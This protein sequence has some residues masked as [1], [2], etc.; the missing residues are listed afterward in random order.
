[1]GHKIKP[2]WAHLLSVAGTL[3]R[4]PASRHG[5]SVPSPQVLT[6]VCPEW[7]CGLLT[8]L[9]VVSEMFGFCMLFDCSIF[10]HVICNYLYNIVLTHYVHYETLKLETFTR[11]GSK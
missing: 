7:L 8:A 4:C 6:P 11:I 3:S 2:W 10:E 5:A 1:M 9:H